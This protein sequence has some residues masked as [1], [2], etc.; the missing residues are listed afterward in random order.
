MIELCESRVK[1]MNECAYVIEMEEC[2]NMKFIES[3][4][5]PDLLYACVLIN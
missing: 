2:T 4:Y 3:I 1:C 5:N